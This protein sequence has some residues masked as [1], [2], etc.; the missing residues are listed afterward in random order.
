MFKIGT[1][2]I[3]ALA[4]A[5]L[6]AARKTGSYKYEGKTSFCLTSK[7]KAPQFRVSSSPKSGGDTNTNNGRITFEA[8]TG[9][10]TRFMRFWLPG[11][12]SFIPGAFHGMDIIPI[13][14]G[15]F[16]QLMN[17]TFDA[18]ATKTFRG[19]LREAAHNG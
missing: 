9:C 14:G 2:Q 18:E 3:I 8:F 17:N 6:K 13:F 5:V 16:S 4:K 12:I 7:I 15:G 11:A 1:Y 10:S 19:M